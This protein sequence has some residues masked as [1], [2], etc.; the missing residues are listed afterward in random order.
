MNNRVLW[1]VLATLIV[2]ACGGGG[3]GGGA[4][5]AANNGG[6]NAGGGSGNTTP[7]PAVNSDLV[8]GAI[9]GFGSVFID[10]QRFDT[11]G[12]T[13]SKDD[14]SVTEDELS[15]GMVVE[16]RGDV[17]AGTA[18][19]VDFEEDIKG[20]LDAISVG[21]D[22]LT[23]M[24]QTVSITP[25][26][27]LDDNLD[28]SALVVGDVLEISG[29]RGVNDLLEA[30]FI[31]DK[32]AADVNAFKVI[33]QIRNLDATAQ[34]FVIG[35]LTV[36]YSVA[37]LDGGVVI[38][39]GATVEVKDENKAYSPGDFNLIASKVEPA[40]FGQGNNG[41]DD[42]DDSTDIGQVQLEGLISAIISSNQFEVAGV[43]INHGANT[44][45][46]YGDVTLL[47]IGT[48]V[49]VE[50]S[51]D[52]DGS[53]TALKIKFARNSARIHG[54]VETISGDMATILGVSVDLSQVQELEDNRDDL[55]PFSVS[56]IMPGDFLEIRGNSADVVIIANEVEREDD[57]DTRVRGPADNVDITER[58]LTILGVSIVTSSNTQYEGLDDEV[59]TAD[60]F[61]NALAAGQ[62]LVDA[63]WDGTVTDTTVAV[64]ELSLED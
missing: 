29:L 28:L 20:P 56:D 59:L 9:T 49:Q 10:G 12:A 22:E 19:T 24:G 31:E 23:V 39:E 53:I 21:L 38:T 8:R 64:R 16:L 52:E 5:P 63:Q 4:A 45:F 33:G 27:V 7:P 13:F 37:Q 15:V 32:L 6:S 18:T 44:Q 61:F 50:G 46:V 60:A 55:D 57:D 11:T 43:V 26:T 36:D 54:R 14:E 48:K 42:N 1:I 30:T 34:T 17:S 41:N 58:S 51:L 2:T 3:G 47:T 25:N 40:G 35:G 62:T